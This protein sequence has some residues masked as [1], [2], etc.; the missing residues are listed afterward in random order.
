MCIHVINLFILVLPEE[1]RNILQSYYEY[2]FLKP[3]PIVQ[4]IYVTLVFVLFCLFQFYGINEHLPSENI[5]TEYVYALY[6]LVGISVLS[7]LYACNNEPGIIKTKNHLLRLN[8]YQ[9]DNILYDK[10]D[11][12]TCK[13]TKVPRSKH[14]NVCN[15][16]IEK[17]DHHCIW[18]NQCVGAKNYKFFLLFISIHAVMCLYTSLLGIFILRD[19][20][21]KKNLYKVKFM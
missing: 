17:F 8:N 16:C 15:K 4:I 12:K 5:T 1:S 11:C 7:Y 3:N 18:I 6:L 19:F 21:E 13:F 2:I 10:E 9:F 20:I 14:C